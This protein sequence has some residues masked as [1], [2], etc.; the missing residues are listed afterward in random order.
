MKKLLVMLLFSTAMF[1]QTI[2]V[3]GVTLS[4]NRVNLTMTL[5]I[6]QVLMKVH[7]KD[8]QIRIIII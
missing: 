6:P 7:N 4:Y 3:R 5:N 8:E 2:K 1:S